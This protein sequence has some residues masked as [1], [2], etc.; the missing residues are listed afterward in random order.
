MKKTWIA[1]CAT[2]MMTSAGFVAKFAYR[3]AESSL[4]VNYAAKA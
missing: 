4:P 2:I 1:V 3:R